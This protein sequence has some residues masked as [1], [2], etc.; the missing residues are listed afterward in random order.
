VNCKA[1][2]FDV[3]WCFR[4]GHQTWE[5]EYAGSERLAADKLKPALKALLLQHYQAQGGRM[6]QVLLIYRDGVSD[7][8]MLDVRRNELDTVLEV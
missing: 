8:E 1:C 5:E 7:G 3:P 4:Y 6:P 2:Q